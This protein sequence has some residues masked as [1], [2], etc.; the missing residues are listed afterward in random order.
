MATIQKRGKS[1][2]IRTYAGYDIDGKQIERTTT[3]TPPA[4][5]TER[6]AE[7]EVL[8]QAILFE[9]KVRNGET[10][11]GRIRFA[12][13]AEEWLSTYA[14]TQLRPR[15]VARYEELLVRINA[16]IG[17]MPLEK[18]R[19][20]HLL[21][22]YKSLS[23][24]EPINA[25][26]QCTADLKSILKEKKFT[27][28][29]FSTHSGISLTTLSTAFQKKSISRCSAE[30]ISSGLGVSLETY[31]QPTVPGTTLSPTTI[32]HYHRLISDILNDA[33]NWQNIP[34]NP[35]GRITAP[36]SDPPDIEYLDDLQAKQLLKLLRVEPGFYRRAATLLLLTGLRRGEILGLEWRD[37]NFSTKTMRISRTSQ[38]LPGKG[39][40][41]DT[42]KNQSS[43]RIVMISDQVIQVLR[44]QYLWQ[45]LQKQTMGDAWIN[46]GRVI[47][48][49]DGS[50]MYPDRLT[51]WFKK[52]IKKTDLPQIHLH[53]LRHTYATLCIAKGVP[54]TAVAEQ[55][56]H[57]SVATTT[58]IYAHAIK[59]AQISATTTIGDLFNED[60]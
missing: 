18:I 55:L 12:D 6:Q 4:G 27:K 14:R 16:A 37:I 28:V 21:D 1:Y 50:P 47:T 41:T 8:R 26:Y 35:C 34:Y 44:K 43:K 5:M 40:Y 24:A 57:A 19:P 46:S 17:H 29:A 49:P 30:K 31:F 7:K 22:F 33:V 3:W 32:Q 15:T 58:K 10:C 48:T 59:S 51:H 2:R 25:S 23:E 45:Q 11:N 52:F 36:K 42:T 54:L 9:E 38:Y 60:L 39:V 53:C 56:G 13:F 20:T